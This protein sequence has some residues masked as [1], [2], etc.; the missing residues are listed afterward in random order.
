MKPRTLIFNFFL[1]IS[2]AGSHLSPIFSADFKV[3]EE[4]AAGNDQKK[5]KK[6]NI[7]YSLVLP[8][9]G[10]WN[11]GYHNR[12]KFF[13]GTEFVLWVGY[14]GFNAYANVIQD[15]Y[16]AY[17]AVHGDVNS[18]GKND[19][20][21]IDIGSADNIYGFNERK[22]RERAD[23]SIYPESTAYYWQWDSRE[24]RRS[25]NNLRV[26]EH[27]WQQRATFV[28]GAFILNRVV[29]AIDVIRIIL[30]ENK[31]D[32]NHMSRMFFN[33]TTNQAGSGIYQFNLAVRW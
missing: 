22:L 1:I 24:S 2:L 3:Q 29:S 23:E 31:A 14:L 7:L 17:A 32:D 6:V 28:V 10:Q 21:W 11:M 16:K 33:Y 9:A 26:N 15:N 20:Y 27:D 13:L 8:G 5:S 12:A 4:G 30:R 25:Y 18:S 19:Q